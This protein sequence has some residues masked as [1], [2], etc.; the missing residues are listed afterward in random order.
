MGRGEEAT[1]PIDQVLSGLISV[2]TD[3][4][5]NSLLLIPV[6]PDAIVRAEVVAYLRTLASSDVLR[7]R[8]AV[9]QT[10]GRLKWNELTPT[11][12]HALSD[13]DSVV[14]LNA[15]RSLLER[16][17]L[18]ALLEQAFIAASP[19]AVDALIRVIEQDRRRQY[20]LFELIRREELTV[21]KASIIVASPIL[22]KRLLAFL[23]TTEI[24]PDLA[25]VAAFE[26]GPDLAT[27]SA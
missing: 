14:R 24:N 17:R 9:A 19:R 11:L 10:L 23:E 21:T 4:I 27:K 18:G 13:Q 15:A 3:E 5:V 6:E 2:D 20:R 1:A 12:F 22:R 16:P 26:P 7:I 8:A 25:S